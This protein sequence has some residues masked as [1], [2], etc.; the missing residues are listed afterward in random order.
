LFDGTDTITAN[1]ASPVGNPY[2]FT[3]RQF[4]PET[5]MQYN[6]ARY[7]DAVLGRFISRDS[8]YQDG[9]NLYAY[10]NGNVILLSDPRGLSI[11][12][13][14]KDGLEIAGGIFTV[15][16]GKALF[17][18]SLSS[19]GTGFGTLV[20]IAGIAAGSYMILTGFDHTQA[21]V[22]RL[23]GRIENQFSGQKDVYEGTFISNSTLNVID[24]AYENKMISN[25]NRMLYMER[26]LSVYYGLELASACA[27]VSVSVIQQYRA[28]TGMRQ[29]VTTYRDQRFQAL[30]STASIYQRYYSEVKIVVNTRE[31]AE[32][33]FVELFSMAADITGQSTQ[34]FP[35]DEEKDIDLLM[36]WKNTTPVPAEINLVE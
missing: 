25:H 30:S 4:D 33:V 8:L 17:A 13:Y 23:I 19:L 31:A 12:D 36:G 20:G 11:W 24:W 15:L 9:P 35:L 6:R 10:V 28:V 22:R 7:Y 32:V 34:N 5:G 27:T 21:G 29:I 2:F 1:G 3:G 16:A 26:G 18:A 14:V